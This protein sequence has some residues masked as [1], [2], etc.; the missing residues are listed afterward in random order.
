MRAMC[1]LRR[2]M[3]Y[4]PVL[5]HIPGGPYRHTSAVSVVSVAD[6]K[7]LQRAFRDTIAR[8][9]PI[10]ADAP[11]NN[12]PSPLLAAAKVKSWSA[13]YRSS[14]G[15]AIETGDRS[16]TPYRPR[17]DRGWEEHNEK[18]IV[19]AEG[20]TVD[21]FIDRFISILQAHGKD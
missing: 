5:G 19:L 8:G 13:L 9:N 10:L 2:G 4:I 7:G 14:V 15:W 18:R 21:D 1:F 11:P 6:S 12:S 20:S 3:V 17:T 16:I